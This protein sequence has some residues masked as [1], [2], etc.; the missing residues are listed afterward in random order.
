MSYRNY[1]KFR[2]M[3]ADAWIWYGDINHYRL[4]NGDVVLAVTRS[5]GIDYLSRSPRSEVLKINSKRRLCKSFADSYKEGRILH[6]SS[7]PYEH[8]ALKTTYFVDRYVFKGVPLRWDGW[9]PK[10]SFRKNLKIMQVMKKLD[11]K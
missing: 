8:W 11:K 4:K 2:K 7:I 6:Q 10:I 3:C 5:I 1:K 9:N